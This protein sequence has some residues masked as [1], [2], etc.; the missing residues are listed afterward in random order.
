MTQL[1]ILR[2]ED[3][4]QQAMRQGAELDVVMAKQKVWSRRMMTKL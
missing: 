2:N 1:D 4:R 3:V